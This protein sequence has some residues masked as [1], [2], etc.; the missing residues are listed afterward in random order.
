MSVADAHGR[1]PSELID[2]KIEDPGGWK[3]RAL[4]SDER[5]QVHGRD[6]VQLR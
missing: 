1:S 2:A 4:L 5:E 6:D 3:G